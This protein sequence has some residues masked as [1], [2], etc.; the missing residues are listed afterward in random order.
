M[1]NTS[2]HVAW[3]TSARDAIVRRLELDAVD[4]RDCVQRALRGWPTGSSA[5]CR[6]LPPVHL[7]ERR[8]D[9]GPR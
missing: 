3:V 1:S 9:G 5:T 7:T 8:I 2:P 4:V 6:Q